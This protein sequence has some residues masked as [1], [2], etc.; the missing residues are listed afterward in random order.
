MEIGEAKKDKAKKK[1]NKV[2]DL[3]TFSFR[4]C[5]ARLIKIQVGNNKRKW[6]AK[7]KS[8]AVGPYLAPSMS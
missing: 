4:C 5:T 8:V 6:M 7:R 3:L 1:R 2:E